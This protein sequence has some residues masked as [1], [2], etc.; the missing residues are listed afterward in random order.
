MV[1]VWPHELARMNPIE[2]SPWL[3]SADLAPER[4]DFVKFIVIVKQVA[5]LKLLLLL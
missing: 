2:R 3:L 4:S 1:D 5:F